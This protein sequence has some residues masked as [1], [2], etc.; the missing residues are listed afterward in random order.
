M[1]WLPIVHNL[2]IESYVPFQISSSTIETLCFLHLFKALHPYDVLTISS[3]YV[4]T[5]Q[6]RWGG[7]CWQSKPNFLTDPGRP[8]QLL[9]EILI[10]VQIMGIIHYLFIAGQEDENAFVPVAHKNA[11][12]YGQWKISLPKYQKWPQTLQGQ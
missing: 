12:L 4:F 5:K 8:P 3:L 11:W 6:F 2:A 7:S 10:L 9:G 1:C